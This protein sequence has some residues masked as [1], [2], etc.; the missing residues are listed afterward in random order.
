V[1]IASIRIV[2]TPEKRHDVL[3][4]LRPILGPT[5]VR[6]GCKECRFYEDIEDLNTL[7]LV[8]GWE[9]QTALESYIRSE[10]YRKVLAAMDL[11]VEKPEVTFHTVTRTAGMEFI[12]TVRK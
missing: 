12:K 3:R 2:V 7:L 1:I 6:G 8:Q 10:E 9:S 11:A 4:T 5:K